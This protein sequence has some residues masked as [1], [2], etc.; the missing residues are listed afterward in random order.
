[1]TSDAGKRI[2]LVDDDEALLRTLTDYLVSEGFEVVQ[3]RD[4]QRALSRIDEKVPDILILDI[5]MPVMGGLEV[6]KRIQTPDGEL[7]CPTLVLTARSAMQGFFRGIAV[8]GF[9]AKPCSQE[10][11]V[12]TIRQILGAKEVKT[13]SNKRT[14][15]KLLIVDHDPQRT[16][17]LQ[18]V[19]T[20]AGYEL[21]VVKTGPEVL[22]RSLQELPAVILMPEALP[23]LNG[24]VVASLVRT[25]PSTH[26]IPIVLYDETR[27]VD[28]SK[29]VWKVPEGVTALVGPSDPWT[30][31]AA[32][33]K[34]L[35]V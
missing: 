17:Q 21:V 22:E 7:R 10:E 15:R 28:D 6:L 9:L 19:F 1:M 25:M 5:S 2:L 3:A 11:L 20:D 35:S 30:L 34:A 14:K 24:S 4:G 27:V 23:H 26:S 31:L 13:R 18:Q 33:E 12:G 32:V 16:L 8:D 29:F